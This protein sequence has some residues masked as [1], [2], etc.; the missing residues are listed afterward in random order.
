MNRFREL[1]WLSVIS[2]TLAGLVLFALRQWTVIPLITRAEHYETEARASHP[3]I[4]PE[5]EGWQPSGAK[6]T[7]FTAAATVLS[8]MGFAAVL[9]AV[10]ALTDERLTA[11][12]GLLWGLGGFLCFVLAPSLGLPPVPPGV[13]VAD[14][15][16]RQVWWLSTV[17]VTA[18]GL[19]LLMNR[20]SKWPVRLAGAICLL[21]PHLIGAPRANGISVVPFPIVRQFILASIWTNAVFWI[22]LGLIG[23]AIWERGH[24]G[25]KNRAVSSQQSA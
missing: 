20:R 24:L 10:V 15:Q 7:L 5:D 22:V 12:R 21:L 3:D 16:L 19:W 18:I 17:V 4:P 6:K 23:G 2:G 1:I 14:L 9:F 25:R 11:A 8:S 13:A